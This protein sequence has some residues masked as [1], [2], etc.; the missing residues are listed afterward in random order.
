MKK[1]TRSLVLRAPI[2]RLNKFDKQRRTSCPC[3]QTKFLFT[4]Q[5][6]PLSEIK[7]ETIFE[8]PSIRG[9]ASP[10]RP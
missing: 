8:K 6:G 9:E 7:R 2:L 5:L 10:S 3:Y 4:L 1:G